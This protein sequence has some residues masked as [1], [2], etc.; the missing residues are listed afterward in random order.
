MLRKDYKSHKP[1]EPQRGRD[2]VILALGI[3]LGAG[4]VILG[5]LLGL[6]R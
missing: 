1:P 4:V 5:Y 3:L 2:L 6:R